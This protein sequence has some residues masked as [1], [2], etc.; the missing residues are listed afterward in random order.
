MTLQPMTG[1]PVEAIVGT[2]VC[3][4]GVTGEMVGEVCC[5]EHPASANNAKHEPN[6]ATR[7]I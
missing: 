7:S 1:V 2:R 3:G 5:D 4:A 6:N